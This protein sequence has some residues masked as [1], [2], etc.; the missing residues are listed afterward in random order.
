MVCV[1]VCVCVGGGGGGGGVV[2]YP[3]SNYM[4]GG[5][6][7]FCINTVASYPGSSSQLFNFTAGRRSLGKRLQVKYSREIQQHVGVASPL[8]ATPTRS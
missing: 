4:K 1:C 2:S 3:D 7:K 8:L 5:A 6:T